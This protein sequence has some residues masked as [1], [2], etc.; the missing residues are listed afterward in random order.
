MAQSHELDMLHHNGDGMDDLGKKS[1]FGET[2]AASIKRKRALLSIN[3]PETLLC[4]GAGQAY[5]ELELVEKLAIPH[6]NVVLLDRRFSELAKDR[7]A[8][9]APQATLIESGLFTY[10]QEAEGR[11]F[12]LVTGFGLHDV[13]LED[14]S[15]KEF[16]RLIPRILEDSAIV[17]VQHVFPDET[18]IP[19]AAKHG[20]APVLD[21][22]YF[23]TPV[24]N[25]N[26]ETK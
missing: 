4:L 5:P 24:H 9:K 21:N 25:S 8:T 19:A 18:I 23:F 22:P 13:L 14:I 2:I 10:L 17:F 20:L 26:S 11:S 16:F 3:R 6:E 1:R 15:L 12:S 7:I